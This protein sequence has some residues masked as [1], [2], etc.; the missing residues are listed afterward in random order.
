MMEQIDRD[1][2]RTHPGLHFFSSDTGPAVTHRE[3]STLAF[4]P[5]ASFLLQLSAFYTGPPHPLHVDI[6]IDS[7][8]CFRI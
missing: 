3:V 8:E 7:A 6:D 4:S 2:M 1:V 5:A